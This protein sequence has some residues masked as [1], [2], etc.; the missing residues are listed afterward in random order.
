MYFWKKD[1]N[2]KKYLQD[3]SRYLDKVSVNSRFPSL[4]DTLS[5]MNKESTIQVKKKLLDV[6]RD[7]VRFKYNSLA[8]EKTYIH[9]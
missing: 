4:T 8:T 3:L 7:K 6:V 1:H 9:T 5:Y 2:Y